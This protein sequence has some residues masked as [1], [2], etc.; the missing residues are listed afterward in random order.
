MRDTAKYAIKYL[1]FTM[2]ACIFIVAGAYFYKLTKAQTIVHKVE[3]A[4]KSSIDYRVFLK[5]NKFFDDKYLTKENIINDKKLLVAELIDKISINYNYV[6]SFSDKV[7]GNYSYYVKAIIESNESAGSKNY[8]SKEYVLTEKKTK[9]L[10]NVDS[11]AVLESVDVKYEDYNKILNAWRELANVSMDGKL[12]VVLVFES[13]VGNPTLEQ[14]YQINNSDI[15]LELPL[16]KAAT[17]ITINENS[18]ASTKTIE[19]KEKSDDSK[20]MKYRIGVVFSFILASISLIMIAIT[21]GNQKSE[22]K[23]Y[24]ELKRI[25]NTYDGIIV[26]VSSLPD[27]DK[28]NVIKV[29]SFDEL[30][31][32]H[33]EVRLPINYY[34]QKH[35]ATFILVNDTMLWMYILRNVD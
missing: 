32:A 29:R 35:K 34:S 10:Q 19:E 3:Y 31:D 17:E 28:F 27:L 13:T 18:N 24:I 11:I 1:L 33:S 21:R 2:L 26:N 8:W 20:Y 14:K 16:S 12:K 23:Y 7:N 6:V 9:E 25:L 22:N 5:E 30:L 15:K 4:E